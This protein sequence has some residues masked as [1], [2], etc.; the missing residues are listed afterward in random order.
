MMVSKPVASR[1]PRLGQNEEGN[2]HFAEVSA[3]KELSLVEAEELLN[4]NP[5]L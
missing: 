4:G 1:A 3:A 5:A 2:R